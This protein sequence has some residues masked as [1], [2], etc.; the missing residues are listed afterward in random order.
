M[1]EE[2]CGACLAGIG[3]LVGAGTAG[4]SSGKRNK[5]RNKIIFWVSIGVT[6]LSIIIGLIF[7]FVK[8]CQSCA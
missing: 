7:L 5:K 1:K 2:F 3:A 8:K 6:I 4:V